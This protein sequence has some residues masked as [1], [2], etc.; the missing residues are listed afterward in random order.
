[1]LTTPWSSTKLVTRVYTSISKLTKVH[2][3][4]VE[5]RNRNPRNL[6]FLGFAHKRQGWQL[7]CPPKD[8]YHQAVLCSSSRHTIGKIV[9]ASGYVAVKASTTEH[10][11]RKHL[12][13]TKD[14]CT[15]FNIGR[16]LAWR[17]RR[18]GIINVCH[19][20][21][22]FL[23]QSERMNWFFKGLESESMKF[24][25]AV[26]I[27]G[28][29]DFEGV[30]YDNADNWSGNESESVDGFAKRD[31]DLIDVETEFLKSR[32]KL[33]YKQQ[34]RPDKINPAGKSADAVWITK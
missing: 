1:M 15:A 12:T 34:S 3:F 31:M 10:C 23:K 33:R 20:V 2:D 32:M 18:A 14:V 25:E 29:Y 30:D 4:P 17:A 19:A 7:Q 28:Q 24:S 16:I 13:S 9:H 6:E 21:S 26:W 8:F 5:I 11:I 27:E 22:H